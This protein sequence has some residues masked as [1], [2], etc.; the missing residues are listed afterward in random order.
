M[1]ALVRLVKWLIITAVALVV[2]AVAGYF[3]YSLYSDAQATE[4]D[5]Q[6]NKALTER[7][8]HSDWQWQNDKALGNRRSSDVQWRIDTEDGYVMRR[9]YDDHEVLAWLTKN[10]DGAI[11]LKAHAYWPADCEDGTS[12]KTSVTDKS[13]EHWYLKCESTEGG[14][15]LRTGVS[16]KVRDL[17]N[18][19]RWSRNYDGF[20][21]D[22]TLSYPWDLQPAVR[23]LTLQSAKTTEETE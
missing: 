1:K 16:F 10:E 3:S 2:L 19:F 22:E 20:E 17:D 9:V 5:A 13:G 12:I 8:N 7:T 23:H 4:A 6:A 21:V 14:S 18:L 11:V 15:Y